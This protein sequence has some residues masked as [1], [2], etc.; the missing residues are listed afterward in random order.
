MHGNGKISDTGFGGGT[1]VRE[2]LKEAINYVRSNLN[3]VTQV[4]KYTDFEY[5]LKE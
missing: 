2:E 4:E 3:R 1:A 5:H